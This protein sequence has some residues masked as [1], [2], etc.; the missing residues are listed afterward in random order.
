MIESEEDQM[1]LNCSVTLTFNGTCEAAFRH[2]EEL[3]GTKLEFILTWGESPMAKEAPPEWAKKIL[4][5]RLNIGGMSIAGGDALPGT[6]EQ[7]SGFHLMISVD[8]AAEGE[9][10]FRALADQGKVTFP[11][12]ETFWAAQYG[13][14]TDRFGIP[15]EINCER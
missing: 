9:K 2:Y 4:Y 10:L 5:A 12:Q 1:N 15:W 7:R 11:L 13:Q 14:L 8:D 3:F 6:D